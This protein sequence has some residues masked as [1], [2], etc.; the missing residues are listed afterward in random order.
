MLAST[1]QF[2]S[3]GQNQPTQTSTTPTNPSGPECVTTSGQSQTY[4]CHTNPKTSAAGAEVRSTCVARSLRT[5]QRAH[6]TPNLPA[7]FHPGKPEV[8]TT[9]TIPDNE[10]I[11]VPP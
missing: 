10:L 1:V 7:A 5:Q 3:Y 2:S 8:L 9:E 4:V 6:T 11:D